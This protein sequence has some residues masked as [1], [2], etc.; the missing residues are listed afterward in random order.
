MEFAYP[1]LVEGTGEESGEV[2]LAWKYLPTLALPDG[3]HNYSKGN[4]VAGSFY[5]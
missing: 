1:P 5:L 3:A 4:C 2:P